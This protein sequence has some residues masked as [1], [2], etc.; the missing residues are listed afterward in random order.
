MVLVGLL[1]LVVSHYVLIGI[2]RDSLETL[3]K[4]YLTRSALSIATDLQNLLS[5]NTQ[6]LTKIAGSIRV[7]K[8]ALPPGTDPFTHAAQSGWISD[9]ITAD[10]DLLALRVLNTAG[11][12]A[13]AKPANLDAAVMQELNLALEAA[14][15]G[16]QYTGTFQMLQSVNQPAV[17]VGVPVTDNGQVI[18]VVEGLISLRRIADRI[19]EEGRGDDTAFLVDRNGRVLLHSE[20]AV[21]VQHPDVSSLNVVKE[22]EKTPVRLTETYRDANGKMV[23]GTVMPVGHPDWGVVVQKPEER[24]Y[25]S[26]D[27]MIRATLMWGGIALALAIIVSVIFAS[28]I[29]RPIGV[30]VQRTHEIAA[31]DYQKRVDLKTHNEIGELAENFNSMS[32]AIEHAV[33]QLK[34][35]AQENHLLFINSVRMLAAAID[36]KDPYTRGHSERVARYS[37]AIGKNL[38]L[39]EK[40]MRNLRVSA[41][42]HD[43]GKIGIDDRVLRKPGALSDDEFEVMKQHPAKGAAIMSGVAQL[44]DVIPGMK[45]HHEK[46][47][48]GGY[49][50]NLEGDAI[51]MQARIVA[52]ADTFDAMT[53][54][55]PYQK[56]M[57]IGYVVEKIKSFAGTR[58]D[59]KVVDA[60][61]NAVA[62]GDITIEEQV[63][64]AA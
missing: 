44:I 25:V 28:G 23:L 15:H 39:P 41:L 58:F 62:R 42:L 31:G 9:Y 3:E 30:L 40:E 45:Y 13:E 53:T 52:I 19:R 49:P 54:N 36:A 38:S 37:I 14:K 63:R 61:V 6:Q 57:E 21:E 50:D 60:F 56:A 7:L 8:T 10:S 18:G 35:A 4:K 29:A 46:W 2:N 20:A 59:P 1:P 24:A 43:V 64:G 27:K 47:G 12:G 48:G 51:P 33:E 22:F 55:R 11:Q 32:G 26:V 16:Q 34:K 17:V 5:S